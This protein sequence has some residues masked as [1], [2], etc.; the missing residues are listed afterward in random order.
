MKRINLNQAIHRFLRKYGV[1]CSDNSNLV[2]PLIF[3]TYKIY[4]QTYSKMYPYIIRMNMDRDKVDMSLEPNLFRL[5]PFLIAEI[6]ITCFMGFGFCVYLLIKQHFTTSEDLTPLN[7]CI[8]V[9]LA[10]CSLAEWGSL[11]IF[12]TSKGFFPALNALYCFKIHSGFDNIT[13]PSSQNSFTFEKNGMMC[14]ASILLW[15]G[16]FNQIPFIS[17]YFRLDPFHYV[18]KNMDDDWAF[19]SH[20]FHAGVILFRLFLAFICV[21]EFCRYLIVFVLMVV[22][23]LRKVNQCLK[24]LMNFPNRKDSCDACAYKQLYLLISITD[25]VFGPVWLLVLSF[26]QIGI[27]VLFW[28]AVKAGPKTHV[29]LTIVTGASVP[30]TIL[31]AATLLS[32]VSPVTVVSRKLLRS[33]RLEYGRL[34]SRGMLEKHREWKALRPCKINCGGLFS[35]SRDTCMEFLDVL[36]RNC[37]DTVLLVDA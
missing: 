5:I 12:A 23:Y 27:T 36:M 29:I 6:L 34:K 26:E 21:L 11:L 14:F 37:V 3:R 24:D 28:L 1:L 7:L 17:T 32:E 35:F 25:A 8:F 19:R 30:V 15:L 13:N 2:T 9:G 4:S 22:L 20:E 18:F 33:K 10:A 16:I 31:I